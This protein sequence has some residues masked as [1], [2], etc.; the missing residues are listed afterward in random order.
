MTVGRAGE[1]PGLLQQVTNENSD[2][3]REARNVALS[4]REGKVFADLS[5]GADVAGAQFLKANQE[6]SSPGVK[7]HGAGF[8][9]TSEEANQLGLDNNPTLKQVIRNYRN[10]RD[11]TQT[12]RGVKVI[13][14]FGLTVDE[15]KR[16]FPSV[17]Q[18]IFERVK[19]ERDQNK[20]ATYRDNW[21]IFG[22]ARKDW[23][24]YANGLPRYIA[25]VETTKHRLFTFLDADILPDNMLVNIAVDNPAWLGALSSRLHIHWAL[26]VGGTLEDRPRY[27][28]TRCFETFPFPELTDE[29]AAKIGQLA[30]QIDAHRKRQQAEHP[31][32]T[33]TGMY[34][35]MEKLRA[36]EELN[37]K[38]QTINQQGLVS[39]LLADHDA[40]DRAV[41]NAYGW[42]DLAKALVGLPGATTPLPD[43]PAAQA[44]AEEELLMRLVALNKQRTA[45]EAQ[46]KV[47]WL[48]P[49]YQAP[50][51]AAPLKK[52]CKALR[53]RPAP[54]RRQN[55]NHLAQRPRHPGHTAAGHARRQPP[56]RGKPGR[57]VQTQTAKRRQRGT[58]RPRR[59][60]PSPAG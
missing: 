34:N 24:R 39:T 36:G 41:F 4:R 9:V 38:E 46:G 28:K 32:L 30:E 27:N 15:V 47:R 22:E 25:T 3:G 42:D 60:R 58:L 1:A 21:W 33:L 23:R 16:Q 54:R 6:I 37:A 50:E 52:S 17:Y 56:Q 19:P 13:D 53:L 14:L 51:E 57:P 55:Q 26:S 7:L 11:L 40:L 48:R 29:Q 35:V 10:G 31:T 2:E 43:K 18:W 8:I 45:E 59:P 12:P 44:E 5:I 49:D 20:R